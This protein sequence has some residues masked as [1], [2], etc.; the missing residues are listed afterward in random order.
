MF[1]LVMI[2]V[3]LSAGSQ[4]RATMGVPENPEGV[5]RRA[6]SLGSRCLQNFSDFFPSERLCYRQNHSPATTIVVKNDGKQYSPH[7]P[8]IPPR[9]HPI[10][11]RRSE[12]V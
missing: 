5:G 11:N 7:I 3:R 6:A 4:G 8:H 12:G 9:I 10:N 2:M 1:D